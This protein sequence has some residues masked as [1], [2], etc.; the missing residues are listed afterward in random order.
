MDPSPPFS[1]AP[2]LSP[3]LGNT[4]CSPHHHQPVSLPRA[5]P[6]QF[7]PRK[8]DLPDHRSD[9]GAPFFLTQDWRKLP[10]AACE[11]SLHLVV[12]HAQLGACGRRGE[13]HQITTGA[14]LPL[15]T[16]FFSL[17]CR[18]ASLSCNWRVCSCLQSRRLP[19]HYM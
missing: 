17:S 12:G 3:T 14:A 11:P 18:C 5:Q 9:N 13:H 1:R 2:F 8:A 7:L 19:G 10:R 4:C 6:C 16:P 15:S